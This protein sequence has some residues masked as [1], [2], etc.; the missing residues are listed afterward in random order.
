MMEE[1]IN[2]GIVFARLVAGR[3]VGMNTEEEERRLEEEL[4][5]HP[6]WRDVYE[7]CMRGGFRFKSISYQK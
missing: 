2:R 5:R 3:K 7:E 6:E 1:K 4:E